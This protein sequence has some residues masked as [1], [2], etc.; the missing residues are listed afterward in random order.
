MVGRTGN[1]IP[2]V[3]HIVVV[4]LAYVSR[5]ALHSPT[6]GGLTLRLCGNDRRCS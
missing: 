5:Y 2:T 1:Y 3:A 6:V 4:I